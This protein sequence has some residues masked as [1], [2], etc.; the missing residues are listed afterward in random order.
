MDNAHRQLVNLLNKLIRHLSQRIPVPDIS[1]VLD[2]LE[3]HAAF[4]FEVEEP[5][6]VDDTDGAAKSRHLQAH[7]Q[8][9]EDV[10]ELRSLSEARPGEETVSAL[11]AFLT[12]WIL[13]HIVEVDV[14]WSECWP[15]LNGRQV[16]TRS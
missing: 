3:E 1:S 10:L 13:L 9:L 6:W 4:L 2:R 8:F 11:V 14:H 7:V 15:N 5:Y 12:R 16:I